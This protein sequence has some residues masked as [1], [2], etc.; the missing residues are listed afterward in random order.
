MIKKRELKKKED[1]M[2]KLLVS[3]SVFV[4]VMTIGFTSAFAGPSSKI[5]A[6]SGT[7]GE[8]I[9]V[10]LSSNIADQ[11]G[12]VTV[13]QPITVKPPNDKDLVMN[14]S[15]ECGL[16]TD[17]TVMSRKLAKASAKA[18][19][20]VEI[21]VLVDGNPVIVGP[22]MT[23]AGGMVRT[24][25]SVIFARRSQELIAS[26]GGGFPQCYDELT[27]NYIIKDSCLE[28]EELQLI[29]DTMSANSFI[30]IATDL[31]PVEHEIEVQAK[32]TYNTDTMYA[33][34]PAPAKDDA[35]ATAA[36]MAYLGYSSF[37]IETV[38]FAKAADVFDLE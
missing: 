18:E 22:P 9:A 14:F 12:W 19:A 30:F 28:K 35:S 5:S 15:A 17:T 6:G 36:A 31:E 8:I 29:L 3:C 32:L 20:M 37:T 38:R 24:G 34:D 10:P 16:T 13:I 4:L 23:D 25:K 27:G 1:K 7:S 26:F 11:E 21:Q 2:K 33:I